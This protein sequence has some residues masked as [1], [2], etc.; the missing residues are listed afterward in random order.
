MGTAAAEEELVGAGA[1]SGGGGPY[2]GEARTT[3][4]RS[5]ESRVAL[6]IIT[7]R[8]WEVV[9]NVKDGAEGRSK[10]HRCFIAPAGWDG[11]LGVRGKNRLTADMSA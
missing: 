6:N 5:V 2:W 4:G 11:T 9:V 7:T 10:S 8:G 3:M 1:G